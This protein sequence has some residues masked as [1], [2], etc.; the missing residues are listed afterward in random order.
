[1]RWVVE[2]IP[3]NSLPSSVRG[4]IRAQPPV[5]EEIP[6][7]P[8]RLLPWRKA[9]AMNV[10]GPHRISFGS[11]IEARAQPQEEPTDGNKE[12][13]APSETDPR[14]EQSQ[15][16]ERGWSSRATLACWV[17]KMPREKDALLPNRRI[18]VSKSVTS[19][20]DRLRQGAYDEEVGG[21]FGGMH[22]SYLD[23]RRCCH[24]EETP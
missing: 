2:K 13:L 20:K 3:R 12:F 15:T 17:A 16:G 6:F 22:R 21:A 24:G 23:Q 11:R 18:A 19:G 10:S 1:M 4:A 8:S 5:R 14:T 7:L 9:C